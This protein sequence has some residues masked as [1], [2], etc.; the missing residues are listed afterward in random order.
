MSTGPDTRTGAPA[1]P[2]TGG[3]PLRVVYLDHCA[4]MS[5]GEIALWRTLQALPEVERTVWLAEDGPLVEPLRA[6]GAHVEVLPMDSAARSVAR[7]EA[8]R[9]PVAGVVATLRYTASLVV[10]LR[11]ERPDVVHTNSLKSALYGSVAARLAGVPVVWHA[12][13]RIADDYLPA[14]TAA[15]VR[16]LARWLPD[17]VV[18][19]SQATLDALQLPAGKPASVIPDPYQPRRAPRRGHPADAPLRFVM[20]GRL[21]PWKGQHVFLAAFA[22]ALRGTRHR[23]VLVG[24]A[25]F[26]ED[27]YAA[28]L[29]RLVEELGI[30][31]QVEF[32]GFTDDVEAVLAAADVLVH[33]ST[34][35]EPFGQVVVEGLAAGL[36]VVAADA[37]GPAEILT[38]EH[39][40][41]L[42]RPDDPSA[43]AAQLRRLATD[44]GLR[45]R[46]STAGVAT[47][48][49]YR[50]EALADLFLGVYRRTR[51][52]H[53]AR[54][55]RDDVGCRS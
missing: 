17:V 52:G 3:R 4:L 18:A 7:T 9:L 22:E 15:V 29:V 41:L 43:L 37:G 13:D 45:A 8:A 27:D 34:V 50:P 26:G 11:H 25:L 47:A 2:V 20:V 55:A 31:E 49:R 39:D 30:G 44:A 6:A 1:T 35:P 40:G 36:A 10:R 14:R 21:A 32:S 54:G 53:G 46:L 28:G 42:V 12:R 19:N 24:A 23:A 48:Q 5:G 51:R 33:A 38:P 16:A